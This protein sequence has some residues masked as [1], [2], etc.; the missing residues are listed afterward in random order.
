M[1]NESVSDRRVHKINTSVLLHL[2]VRT[3]KTCP[4][5][6][7]LFIVCK[8]TSL[9][10]LSTCWSFSEIKALDLWT[11]CWREAF[12]FSNC[13]FKV[14][15]LSNAQYQLNIRDTRSAPVYHR[16]P[17]TFYKFEETCRKV[18]VISSLVWLV[19][20]FDIFLC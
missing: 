17:Q 5:S 10:R 2:S 6:K 20:I 15:S 1:S 19:K 12:S 16:A 18:R 13:S 14:L 7:N 8:L 3:H 11:D 4:C 9:L